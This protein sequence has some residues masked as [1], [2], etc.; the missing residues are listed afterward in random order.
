MTQTCLGEF[1]HRALKAPAL[2]LALCGALLGS[3]AHAQE[4]DTSS[5]VQAVFSRLDT[6]RPD[7]IWDGVAQLEALGPAAVAEVARGLERQAPS[8]L[9]A[10]KAL[11]VMEG[12]DVYRT[13][14][15]D[16]L[17]ALI[18]DSKLEREVRLM[19]SELLL[20]FG[21]KSDIRRLQRDVKDIEDPYVQIN[22]FKGLRAS[23]RESLKAFLKSED[24]ALRAEA[25]LALAETGNVTAAKTILDAIKSEPTERGRRARMYLE[26]ERMLE[27]LEKYGG[28]EKK[29]AIIDLQKATIQRLE[30]DLEKA[31]VE[32]RNRP[33]EGGGPARPQQFPQALGLLEELLRKIQA[34]Y[35]DEKKVNEKDLA[36]LAAKGLMEGLD[37]FSSYMPEEETKEFERSIRQSYAGIGAVVQ[38]DPRTGFL[39]VVRPIYG[40]PAY[41]KG[42]RTLDR[43]LEVEGQST[44]GKSVQDLVA[45]L[46]G[47]R[48]T[49]V[50]VLVQHFLGD[51]SPVPVTIQRDFIQLP[52]VSYELIPGQIGYLQ[53]S[54]FGYE[55]VREVKE[56]VDNLMAQGMRGLIFDL[57]GNPGG[58]LNA[59]V[60]IC[61]LFLPKGKLIVYQQGRKETAVGRRKEFYSTEDS[62]YPDFPMVI[63]IDESSASASEIVSGALKAHK[64]ATLVGERTFGKGSVQQ[65]Y[66]VDAT[67]KKS[68]LR[69][70]IAYYYLPDGTCIHR[71]RSP[72]G[73]R[74]RE[75]LN[76]E[77]D[78]WKA[79]G[80]INE[81]QA[82]QLHD[83]YKP[84]PGGVAPD[85]DVSRENFEKDVL[86][87][88]GELQAEMTIE[89]HVQA[90]YLANRQLLQKLAVF[91]DENPQAYPGF[92][93][94]MAQIKN[95]LN[96]EPVRYYLR[97][98][99]RRFVQD[100][101]GRNL[102]SDFQGDLQIERGVFELSRKA[103]LN[104]DSI[105]SRILLNK[106]VL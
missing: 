23:G 54:Q 72:S 10:A 90:T 78:R 61:N 65:L 83:I 41:S 75:L 3:L 22:V 33:A 32:A 44:K 15:I 30:K 67:E 73:W 29:E 17:Q 84:E 60:G 8:R 26:R 36:D 12:G 50:K 101:L 14:A 7:Q 37:P 91:D 99:V 103:G 64:R 87:K 94:L 63:L 4:G 13:K 16:A 19:A 35:V 5:K 1:M 27:R 49:P 102:P 46:K 93:E 52:S 56:A 82:L 71:E 28:L 104:I 45:V 40:G 34:F 76:G 95:G 39:T 97:Q 51:Q 74:F 24:P 62:P 2:R 25:A 85:F 70:T 9:G 98:T 88:L 55:A 38:S 96:P 43:I 58:L 100:D 86:I 66:E 53:L 31:R 79:D 6:S 80:L 77:I 21:A 69:L 20:N 92:N 59:A 11:L 18:V 42:L 68:R 57:R 105:G 89:K 81:K 48:G 106:L 47:E